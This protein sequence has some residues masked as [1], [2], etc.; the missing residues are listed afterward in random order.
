[1]ARCGKSSENK[2]GWAIKQASDIIMQEGGGGIQYVT[3]ALRILIG[4]LTP[5]L[6][7]K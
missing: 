5:K 7:N 4:I 2:Q 6:A 1:L 3:F